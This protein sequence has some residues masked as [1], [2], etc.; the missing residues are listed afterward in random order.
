MRSYQVKRVFLALTQGAPLAPPPHR[1]YATDMLDKGL[2]AHAV[3]KS[4]WN[5]WESKMDIF[6]M[7]AYGRD[8]TLRPFSE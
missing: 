4:R 1:S 2:N 7:L 5:I 8:V 3:L 6:E